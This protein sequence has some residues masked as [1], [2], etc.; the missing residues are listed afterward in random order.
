MARPTPTTSPNGGAQPQ[1]RPTAAFQDS[2]Q[3]W[4]PLAALAPTA[5]GHAAR[6]RGRQQKGGERVAGPVPCSR[7]A[8]PQLIRRHSSFFDGYASARSHWHELPGLA[9]ARLIA[10]TAWR[11]CCG[12]RIPLRVPG[13]EAAIG[14][15]IVEP[16]W[17]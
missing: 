10:A 5:L 9:A 14:E 1:V 17:L 4:A 3:Y 7:A 15:E 13:G 12:R 8:W 6:L 16:D 11:R 2:A